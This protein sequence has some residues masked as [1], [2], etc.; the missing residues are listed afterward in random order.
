M[1]LAETARQAVWA[2]DPERPVTHLRT[3]EDSVADAASRFRSNAGFFAVLAALALLLV[4]LG[5]Y[6]VTRH[7]LAGRRRELGIRTALGAR[8]GDLI[9]LE[10]VRVARLALLGAVPGVL[11]AV[12]LAR[13][14]GSLLY[15]VGAGDLGT[16]LAVVLAVLALAVAAALHPAWKA[17]AGDPAAALRS[18]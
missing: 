14:L 5:I 15:G 16:L 10:L 17:T 2:R 7:S 1:A 11:V 9:R 18:E 6:G 13:T 8:R 4:G 12:A 3:L